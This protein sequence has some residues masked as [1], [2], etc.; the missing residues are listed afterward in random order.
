MARPKTIRPLDLYPN[1]PLVEGY[2]GPSGA[3]TET[4]RIVVKRLAQYISDHGWSLRQSSEAVGVNHVSLHDMLVGNTWP[5]AEHIAQI[6]L[7]LDVVLWPTPEEVR[8]KIR[9]RGPNEA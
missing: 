5:G 8:G 7:V 2:I 6:E 4:L 9:K 3:H 1:W